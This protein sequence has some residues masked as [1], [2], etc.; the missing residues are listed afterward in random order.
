MTAPVT[1]AINGTVI[2]TLEQSS[3]VVDQVLGTPI[4]TA[5][6]RIY[7]KNR[8]ITIPEG[9][10]VTITR[11]ET[12]TVIFGGLT[13]FVDSWTE[14]V[15]RWWEVKAQDYTYLLDTTYVYAS[16]AGGTYSDKEIILD[17]F[18]NRVVGDTVK[19]SEIEAATYVQERI[20]SMAAI[21]FNY[22][23]LREAMQMICNFSGNNFYVDG[24]KYLHYFYLGEEMTNTFSLVDVPDLTPPTPYWV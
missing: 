20:A 12:N 23:T 22:V 16:Y 1:L 3:F 6:V 15:S 2:N 7:D 24:D 11:T 8:T 10:D 13:S 14:G 4:D 17:L 18:N 19:Y 9:K 5:T 21:F